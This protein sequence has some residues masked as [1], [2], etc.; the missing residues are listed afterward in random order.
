M[1]Y[2]KS[3]GTIIIN[4]NQ[5][6]LIKHINGHWDF[7]KG[8]MEHNE[9]ELETATRETKEET[10][11]DVI[12]NEAY[13][14]KISYQPKEN[15][16]KDVVFYLAK[17]LNNNYRPQLTEVSEVAWFEINDALDV[18]TFKNA[19]EILKKLINDLNMYN[20]G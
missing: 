17:P 5:V 8:H 14:Y 10:N 2:E 12:I 3:C 9:T 6:L 20:L 7:P 19:K 1:K 13:R 11:I 18:L 4:N 16:T 15:I